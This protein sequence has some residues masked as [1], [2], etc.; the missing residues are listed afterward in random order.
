MSIRKL[1]AQLD[2]NMSKKRTHKLQEERSELKK[3]L[4]ALDPNWKMKRVK[5]KV[6]VT[7]VVH[8]TKKDTDQKGACGGGSGKLEQ[9]WFDNERDRELF[10]K[11]DKTLTEEELYDKHKQPAHLGGSGR[12]WWEVQD[13]NK[14]VLSKIVTLAEKDVTDSTEQERTLSRYLMN[15]CWSQMLS[16]E[17]TR[18]EFVDILGDHINKRW[19]EGYDKGYTNGQKSKM[20]KE[21]R[22]NARIEE[23][24]VAYDKALKAAEEEE[25]DDDDDDD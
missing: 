13:L 20:T 16:G 7:S 24:K 2:K 22:K 12:S 17:M 19:M 14:D 6:K 18:K 25:E 10:H 9:G 3:K 11:S 23:A 8:E 21:E 1:E 5:K 15:G 4:T